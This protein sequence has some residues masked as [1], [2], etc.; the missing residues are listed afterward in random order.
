MADV[1]IQFILCALMVVCIN[2]IIKI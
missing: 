1:S 2:C